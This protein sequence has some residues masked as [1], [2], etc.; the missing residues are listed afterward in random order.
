MVFTCMS[1]IYIGTPKQKQ[2]MS[3]IL[4]NPLSLPIADT[5]NFVFNTKC[6]V[7]NKCKYADSVSQNQDTPQLKFFNEKLSM[8]LYTLQK[9]YT[10]DMDEYY[11]IQGDLESDY[12]YLSRDDQPIQLEFISVYNF[13]QAQYVGNGFI[14]LV[15][16]NKN[17]IFIQGQ[18]QNKLISPIFQF[19]VDIFN[20][21]LLINYNITS[22]SSYPIVK[23]YSSNNWDVQM[24]GLVLDDTDMISYAHYQTFIIQTYVYSAIPKNIAKYLQSKYTRYF[25]NSYNILQNC[26]QCECASDLPSLE[27]YTSQYKISIPFEEFLFTNSQGQC[28]VSISSSNLLFGIRQILFN[29][30]IFNPLEGELQFPGLT[31]SKK[32][33][34]KNYNLSKIIKKQPQQQQQEQQQHQQQKMNFLISTIAVLSIVKIIFCS[35]CQNNQIFSMITQSCI[36]CSDNCQT[37]F[38]T[39]QSSCISCKSNLF[40]SSINSSTC[41]QKC[42]D[43]SFFNQ[44]QECVKCQVYGCVQCDQSQI[45]QK[46]DEILKLDIANN[47]CVLM[48]NVC[49]FSI[50]YVQ[51][52]QN[53]KKC[54]QECSPTYYQNMMASTCE[55]TS[56]CLQ[57][58]SSQRY[59][60]DQRVIEIQP[61][62][63]NQYLVAANACTFA[64]VDNNWSIIN[65][66]VLQNLINYED[67]YMKVGQEI[68]RKSFIVGDQ[69]GCTA[70]NRL[71]VM[72]FKNLKVLFVQDNTINDYY[73]LFVDSIN[74]IVFLYTTTQT[75]TLV[76]Y[77]AANSLMQNYTNKF[78]PLNYTFITQKSTIT[79]VIFL[80]DNTIE[81]FISQIYSIRNVQYQQIKLKYNLSDF[82]YQIKYLNPYQS[83]T[84]YYDINTNKNQNQLLVTYVDKYNKNSIR[85]LDGF[86]NFV[87]S[88]SGYISLKESVQNN[89]KNPRINTKILS[90]SQNITSYPQILQFVNKINNQYIL[91]SQQIGK[92]IINYVYDFQQETQILQYNYSSSV[93]LNNFYYVSKRNLLLINNVPQIY[94]LS[95]SQQLISSSQ[96]SVFSLKTY[97]VINDDYLVYQFTNSKSQIILYLVDF[98]TF[99][100]IQIFNFLKIK[101]TTFW[102]IY[103]TS[104]QPVIFNNDIIYFCQISTTSPIC[105]PF[106]ILQ[107]NFT[108]QTTQMQIYPINN[109]SAFYQKTNEIFIF[110]YGTVLICS[111][112]LQT[113][114]L[115]KIKIQYPSNLSTSKQIILQDERYVFYSDQTNFYKFDMELKSF[116]LIEAVTS[117]RLLAQ[118]Y[119]V[120]FYTIGSTQY[121]KKA[122]NVIDTSNM[123]VIKS[124]Q[125]NN[126]FI[127]QI[128]MDDIQYHMFQSKNGVYWHKNLL[129]IPFQIL[130]LTQSQSLQD[131]YISNGYNLV[132]IYDSDQKLLTI[133]NMIK[134]LMQITQITLN[135]SFDLTITIVDWNQGQFIYVKGSYI[136]LYNPQANINSQQIAQLDSNI[137]EYQYCVMQ[138]IIVA[139]TQLQNVFIIKVIDGT[140]IQVGT[141]FS[142]LNRQMVVQL[143]FKLQCSESLLILYS[144]ILK[145]KD[146]MT[147]QDS[148]QFSNINSLQLQSYLQNIPMISSYQKLVIFMSS[149]FLNYFERN[150]NYILTELI[151]YRQ[152]NT[153]IY[154]DISQNV[155]V[156]ATGVTKQIDVLNIPGDEILFI[157]YTNNIFEQ[158]ATYFFQQ[159]TTLVVVDTT[160]KIYLFNY[161][162][163]N[164]TI[165][166]TLFKDTQGIQLDPSKNIIFLYSFQFISAFTYPQM[167]YIEAFSLQQYNQTNI[168]SV[169]IY[170]QISV[171]IVQ[172]STAFIAFDLT[173]IIY[174]SETK[175]LEYQNVQ[176][177]YLNEEYQIFYSLS[178][179]SLNLFKNAQLVDSLL[180]E[181]FQQVSYPYFTQPILISNNQFIYI[182]FNYLNIIQ[183]NFQTDSLVQI[184][185]IVLQTTP[186]NYFYD[187]KQNQIF[188]FYKSSYQLNSVQLS[189]SNQNEVFATNLQIGDIQNSF[190]CSQF[191]VVP[192]GNLIQVYNL[193][194]NSSSSIILPQQGALKLIFK[195]QQFNNLQNNWWQIPFENQQRINNYDFMDDGS[196]IKNILVVQKQDSGSVLYILDLLSLQVVYQYSLNQQKIMNVVNDPFRK[197]IYIVTNEATTYIFNYTLKQISLIQ[198]PCLKQAYISYDINFV[199]SICPND[200]IIYNGLSFEQQ[201]P[202]I[203]SGIQEVNNLINMNYN[204]HLIL[205]QKSKLSIIQVKYNDTYQVVYE[206]SQQSIQVHS[207]Q[208][209]TTT[210]NQTY[211][212]ITISNFQNITQLQIPLQQNTICSYQIQQQNRAYEYMNTKIMLSQLTQSLQTTIQK[213][214]LVEITFLDGQIIQE[215]NFLIQSQNIDSKYSLSLRLLSQYQNNIF[216][217]N[218]TV[219]SSQVIN[220]FFRDMSLNIQTPV[221]LNQNNIMQNFEIFNVSLNLNQSLKLQNFDKVYLRQ[222][223]ISP[224]NINQIIISNCE[225]VVIDQLFLKDIKIPQLF[226]FSLNNNTNIIIN[227]VYISDSIQSNFIQINQSKQVNIT[228]VQ[229]K[230]CSNINYIFGLTQIN[231]LNINN[232]LISQISNS[233]IYNIQSTIMSIIQQIQIKN[234]VQNTVI[235]IKEQDINTIQ[236]LCDTVIIKDIALQAIVDAAFFIEANVIQLQNINVDN[237]I[238]SFTAFN[239]QVN[240]INITNMNVTNTKP[241]VLG[242]HINLINIKSFTDLYIENIY[243]NNNQIS[244]LS[245][246]Q[247]QIGGKAVIYQ[248]S[249]IQFSI[250]DNNPLIFFDSLQNIQLQNI[251]IQNVVSINNYYSSVF[252]INNCDTINIIDSY[253]TNCT[254]V[255]G[256]GGVIYATENKL[257]KI[258]NSTFSFNQCKVQNGGALYIVNQIQQGVLQIDQSQF[259]NNQAF[260]SSGGAIY[261]VNNN[262]ILQNSE[263][264][265]NV[266]Q[267]GGGIYYSQIIPDF[268]L[269]LQIYNT[270]NN[271]FSNNIGHIYGQNF[272]STLRKIYI[273]VQNIEAPSGSFIK[274]NDGKIQIQKF[275]SGNKIK[276]SQIQLLDEEDN[277]IKQINLNSTDFSL[278]NSEVQSLIQQISIS[279]AWDL[280]NE[281]IQCIGQL[282]TKEFANGGYS[283]EFQVLY[284]PI[285]NMKIKIVSNSFPQLKDSKGNIIINVGLLEQ[286]IKIYLEQCSVGEIFMQYGNSIVCESCPS[287]KYSLNLNDKQCKSCPESAVSC[288]GSNI[289]LKNGYWR[290]NENTDQIY[291][292]SFNPQSCKPELSTSKLNCDKGYKG[293]LC[294][295]CDT[296][297]QIW[298]EK[299]SELFNPGFCYQ[300]NQSDRSQVISKILTDHLQILYLVYT[301]IVSLPAFF[302]IPIFLSGNSISMTSKSIDC[303]LSNYQK[304]KPLW[305]F[306]QLWSFTLPVG[307]SVLYCLISVIY[308][309]FRIKIF[310]K[311]LRTAAMFIYFYFFPMVLTIAIRSVNCISIGDKNY[312]DLDLNIL[313]F[314]KYEHLPYIFYYSVPVLISWGIL[315]PAFY[316]YKIYYTRQNNKSIFI[317]IKYS[318]F[319]S[320]YNDK[321]Y[322]WEFQKLFY[323]AILI[324]LSVF[325]NQNIY[326]K[327]IYQSRSL[328][329]H[330]NSYQ[331]EKNMNS[332]T[333]QQTTFGFENADE[334]QYM[335]K[336]SESIKNLRKKWPYYIRK[337][338]SNT[339]SEK[340]PSSQSQSIFANY[341]SKDDRILETQNSLE[342]SNKSFSPKFQ[343]KLPEHKNEN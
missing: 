45:C 241:F 29:S 196:F 242:L 197:L 51:E 261:L 140:K 20:A 189:I 42:D 174:A 184:A 60:F 275:K 286:S 237:L 279:I 287:G 307:V 256:P 64:L 156:A 33:N 341:F 111:Q 108:L 99:Q 153:N 115:L 276:L 278:L 325:L 300:L 182:T 76:W 58:Q 70:G 63:Q 41:V 290:E 30:V 83:L 313:C 10:K 75:D 36:Q 263:F 218:S 95:N 227:G 212:F 195:L 302:T 2:P 59:Y 298:G 35:Q 116:Q 320:G 56:K 92:T 53:L 155:L 126:N 331:T 102:N 54:I 137:I 38:D 173:E 22:N 222:L 214:S 129:N 12:F 101:L 336:G 202:S 4:S 337:S 209:I 342:Y 157:Y 93:S 322:Y 80:T 213:I 18:L 178:N 103:S 164:A 267:I 308:M 69:G 266:A 332:P 91:L 25:S 219:F 169:Y 88:K 210:N 306:Q 187:Y 277:P 11:V 96:L 292:C 329:E 262:L 293:P 117:I 194:S 232:T 199:Y 259:R 179:L 207:F 165:F 55:D 34:Q 245:I 13:T 23:T 318:F 16:G 48:D 120:D 249:F 260:L 208:L 133:Y 176:N 7:L 220:L 312:L 128:Q 206:Y 146:L 159:Q 299:Y 166:S 244:I 246:N 343:I 190:I 19:G 110:Y 327:D 236:Y 254:N 217:T 149:Q 239:I 235:Q 154:Y 71:I 311:Y 228:N 3:F 340:T 338:N 47:Q 297:G 5:M 79:N 122:G 161:V 314:D 74:Q 27:V 257:I 109:P 247:Q 148:Q 39:S 139:K 250:S 183:V 324:V 17:G 81:V 289:Q 200:I 24:T 233:T 68:N 225:L 229:V 43:G 339:L 211:A 280:Q 100:P 44:N 113:Q 272:G 152:D 284:K 274:E 136:Y 255:S 98:T 162:Q 310:I 335:I 198:N 316:F 46:C 243:S 138:Q 131:K 49:P 288:V 181:T 230:N 270:N 163:R 72:D 61:I 158:G 1:N 97:I 273:D 226:I 240:Q 147:G 304:L 285:S 201:F 309:I 118:Y 326:L 6:S 121:I 294:Q 234:S 144:P 191:I 333:T 134:Q 328:Q 57:I 82:T 172:T 193:Q 26:D 9:N 303:I 177:L 130:N 37:C 271:T 87:N 334:K 143:K 330:F 321:Y 251:I 264:F 248:S 168:L 73:V 141:N 265:S 170:N 106:S 186:D 14:N 253:F 124:Q 132:A 231:S 175:L 142:Y 40:K 319:F 119:T 315:L 221:D 192:S 224:Q 15:N 67:L 105:Q 8:S 281:Q 252:V 66:Q 269:D 204:N 28:E 94:N 31:N 188:L 107:K 145:I 62:N 125:E 123:I 171:M 21:E 151:D 305:L 150:G 323:K 112:D 296:Y 90:L 32:I 167:Q 86:Q 185:K 301:F 65:V 89:Q 84:Q 223:T 127:G 135:F 104:L 268:L 77:N 238:N 283:L 216:W 215:V 205:V 203:V 180:F 85:I 317:M 50:S 258:Q 282:S 78:K 52:T 114:T 160:P 295:S 291:E